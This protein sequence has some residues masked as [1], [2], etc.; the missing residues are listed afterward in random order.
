[1]KKQINYL[2]MLGALAVTG[3]FSSCSP[4]DYS[5]ASPAIIPAELVEGIAYTITPSTDNPNLI[6]CKSDLGAG[7]NT[8]W[9][10]PFGI[11]RGND[12]T[13][14]FPFPGDYEI[15]FGVD[16]GSGYVWGEPYKF[17]VADICVDFLSGE[18]WEQIAG[19]I[20]GSKTWVYDG[21]TYG[22]SAG[23]LSYGDPTANP[24]LGLNSFTENWTPGANENHCGDDAMW[25]SYMTFDLMDGAHYT[26]YDSSNDNTQTGTF[27]LDDQNYT[28]SF[29]NAELMHPSTWSQRLLDWRKGFQIVELSENH[30]RV[31]YIR[32]PG[33]WGTEWV[34]CFNYLSKDFVDN[35]VVPAPGGIKVDPELLASLTTE[36]KYATWK[37]DEEVPFDWFTTDGQ[38]KNPNW[39][40]A[41]AYPAGYQPLT[42]DYA[43]YQ[44]KF[45]TPGPDNYSAGSV[46]GTYTMSDNGL[47]TLSNGVEGIQLAANI[48][49]G[50]PENTLQVLSIELDAQGRVSDLWLGA[51]E[52]DM[53]GNDIQYLGYHFVATYGGVSIPTFPMNLCYN[54]TSDWAAITGPTAFV[55]TDGVYEVS[56]TGS[57]S[58]MDP[59]VWV[60]CTKILSKYPNCYLKVLK[61]E[62]DGNELPFV[63]GDISVDVG[64]VATTA[65]R[66]ICNPWGLA[67]C[68]GGDKSLFLFNTEIK[69][70]MQVILDTGSPNHVKK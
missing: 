43:D 8:A 41:S 55:T 10:T 16:T 11:S 35:Y 22:Y 38:R 68:F 5:L 60:D 31:A 42:D 17:S 4:D 69:V 51:M 30:M 23:P 24:S 53:A 26:F 33:N 25:G 63:D 48:S 56:V 62:I 29:N 2:L 70:T 37:F 65:R 49:F 58:K 12:V 44:L 36:M 15:K 3:M 50:S 32:I 40:S 21:G 59:C 19:G 57:N 34:E 28:L 1:M 54:N 47:F 52:K 20:N 39:S 27:S 45:C 7:R 61:I 6:V 66:Y 67:A 9:Q 14:R 13:L 64:D 18:V 46:S